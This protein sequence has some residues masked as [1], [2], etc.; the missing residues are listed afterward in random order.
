MSIFLSDVAQTEFDAEVKQAYQATPGLRG[1]V[2]FRGG[3]VGGTYDFRA[4]GKGIAK[5][6]S[7]QDDVIPMNVG[8]SLQVATLAD[9]HAAE[10]TDIFKQAE[11]NFDEQKELAMAIAQA[12]K[13][14]E[15]QLIINALDDASSTYT[16]ATSIGG[17]NTNLNVDKLRKASRL[18]N[19]N[20]VPQQGRH[21]LVNAIAL[22]SLLGTTQAT[23]S[24]YN[25]VK[26]L[27]SGDIDTFMGFKF[28]L[29]ADQDEGGLLK[30]TNDRHIFAYHEL[31]IGLAVAIDKAVTVDWVPTKRSH[32][33]CQDYKA[34]AV[35]RDG[36]AGS[37]AI[38]GIVEIACYE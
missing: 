27:V 32:L 19:A 18:M 12:I 34:G 20:G 35:A 7:A 1:T 33:A 38:K 10:Y 26:A 36:A 31:A 23:S 37:A 6:K 25:G 11:V 9:W 8:H 28:H 29:V 24:D 22:E 13:R 4:M 14:R 15:D 21:I 3:V 17:T 16:V 2:S 5:Q 30:V